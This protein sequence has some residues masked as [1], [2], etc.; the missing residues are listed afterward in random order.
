MGCC[1][2]GLMFELLTLGTDG[3]AFLSGI[4]FRACAF[5]CS[6]EEGT[7]REEAGAG[8]SSTSKRCL[9]LVAFIQ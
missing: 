3:P 2:Q 9:C 5:N 7:A 8:R 4:R 6:Q 1:T